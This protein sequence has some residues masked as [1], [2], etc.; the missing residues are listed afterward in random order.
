MRSV[1]GPRKKKRSWGCGFLFLIVLVVVCVAAIL[2]YQPIW[3]AKRTEQRLIDR[4]GY[5]A[6][7]MPTLDG[8]ISRQRVEAFLRVREKMFVFCPAFQQ[9]IKDLARSGI[10]EHNG[11]TTKTAA[12]REGMDGLKKLFRF[13][14]AVLNFIEVRNHAL[15]EEEMG[16]GE[17]IYIYIL[18]YAEPLN[19]VDET[20]F[21]GIEQAYVGN[22]ARK[23]L[24]QMLENQL[25]AL[26]QGEAG[27]V[28][29]D[30][31]AALQEQIDALNGGRQ[32]FPWEDGLPAAVAASLAPYEKRLSQYYCEG[33]AK[34]ELMQKNKGFNIKN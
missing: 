34:I 25:G 17:Y 20:K 13:G 10:L 24:I 11:D 26:T 28:D 27:L 29:A 3:R 16:L 18:A 4:F 31:V 12:S 5:A 32:A 23:E 22:R 9:K 30:M 33:I 15:L 6:E 1:N 2:F 14:P 7:Y 19:H 21:A 8:S